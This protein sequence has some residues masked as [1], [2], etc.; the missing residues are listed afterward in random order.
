M[1]INQAINM[2]NQFEIVDFCPVL[3]ILIPLIE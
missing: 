2:R 1:Y 3:E